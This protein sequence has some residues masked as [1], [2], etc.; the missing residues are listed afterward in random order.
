MG[1]LARQPQP[2]SDCVE[3][4]LLSIEQYRE[5]EREKAEAR[6]AKKELLRG[7]LRVTKAAASA[8]KGTPRQTGVK[9]KIV[10]EEPVVPGSAS[11]PIHADEDWEDEYAAFLAKGWM[12]RE[13]LNKGPFKTDKSEPEESEE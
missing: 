4:F 3:T 13:R 10:S 11:M 8:T 6:E 7:K 2:Q 12:A 5:D 9:R 1:W